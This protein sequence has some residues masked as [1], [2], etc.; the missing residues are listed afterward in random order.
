MSTK[1]CKAHVNP[2]GSVL[3]T[4]WVTGMSI[5]SDKLEGN[6]LQECNAFDA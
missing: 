4:G 2:I 5:T 6:D 3:E 1:F